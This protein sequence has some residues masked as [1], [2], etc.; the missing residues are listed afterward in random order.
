M[1]RDPFGKLLAVGLAV[2][3]ILQVVVVA[4]A[5]WDSSPLTGKALSF[6]A[7]VR[8]CSRTG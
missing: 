5:S 1:A 8:H 4:E 2:A 3:L 6:L 7:K